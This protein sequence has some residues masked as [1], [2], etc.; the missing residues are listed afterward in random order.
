VGVQPSTKAFK[1]LSATPKYLKRV[2]N[3][4]KSIQTTPS[5]K[6]GWLEI[7]MKWKFVS[8]YR[9]SMISLI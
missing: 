2:V 7:A 3:H 4:P 6:K 8:E 5:R 9:V 1:E